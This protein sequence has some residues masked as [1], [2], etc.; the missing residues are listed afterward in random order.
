[1]PD[2]I[3]RETLAAQGI[4][5][6][7]QQTTVLDAQDQKNEALADFYESLKDCLPGLRSAE[8][9]IQEG[10]IGFDIGFR[11]FLELMQTYGYSG[12]YMDNR[13][14]VT[15][16][17]SQHPEKI[18][19]DIRG[20]QGDEVG[21]L[22][23]L[24]RNMNTIAAN[25]GLPLTGQTANA[26]SN[27]EFSL[28][29]GVPEAS[30]TTQ[31]G[32]VQ[33]NHYASREISRRGTF[34]HYVF[35]DSGQGGNSIDWENTMRRPYKVENFYVGSDEAQQKIMQPEAG[36]QAVLDNFVNIAT[37]DFPYIHAYAQQYGNR[38]GVP[39]PDETA[40]LQDQTSLWYQAVKWSFA[41]NE[42]SM[43]HSNVGQAEE[44]VFGEVHPQV[45]AEALEDAWNSD[46]GQNN[47]LLKLS[48]AQL[49]SLGFTGNVHGHKE[50]SGADK[51][52]GGWIKAPHSI[53]H[54]GTFEQIW[55]VFAGKINSNEVTASAASEYRR[56][57]GVMTGPATLLINGIV[58]FATAWS[59][60]RDAAMIYSAVLAQARADIRQAFKDASGLLAKALGW[61]P[62]DNRLSDGISNTG[63]MT[64]L[65][66]T[67][68]V[69]S[70]AESIGSAIQRNIFKEQCF[71]LSY[72]KELS[73][74]KVM[75]DKLGGIASNAPNPPMG[76]SG[77]P[78]K[79]LPYVNNT[80]NATLLVDGDPYGFLNKLTLSE[81]GKV[82][83]NTDTEVLDHLQPLIR[84]FKV[85]YDDDGV[86]A[87]DEFIFES[88]AASLDTLLQDRRRRGAGVG[89]QSF[90]F[91]Y[92][93]SN[94]FAVKKSISAT[95]KI[96]ASSMDEL[97]IPRRTK[98]NG[99]LISFAD[100][101]LKTKNPPPT[102][103]PS[104][105]GSP[106]PSCAPT[107][108]GSPSAGALLAQQ[109]KNLDKLTFRLKAVVGWAAPTGNGPWEKMPTLSS[110]A[111]TGKELLYKGIWN[112]TITLNLTP[113][114]HHFEF[115]ELGRT[116][117][118]IK[119]LAYVEDFYDQPAFNV[120]ATPG[121]NSPTANQI[122]RNMQL[123]YYS[124]VCEAER[125]ADVK[126]NLADKANEEKKKMM[127]SLVT[128]LAAQ[129]KIYTLHL[130]VENI[131]FFN[132]QG[133][134]YHWN[135][136][137]FALQ[138]DPPSN[139]NEAIRARMNEALAAYEGFTAAD[140][141]EETNVFRAGL[142]ATNPNEHSLPFVYVSDLIDCIMSNIDAELADLPSQVT[143][144]MATAEGIDNDQCSLDLEKQRLQRLKVSYEK[145][146]I[147]LGPLEI[148]NQGE[149][150]GAPLHCTFGD[151]PIS[152]KY[153]LEWIADELTE[154]AQTIYTLTRFLNDLFN[155]LIAE[156]LND[157]SCFNWDI[158][159]GGKVRMNQ[160]VITSYPR[161][162]PEDEITAAAVEI[163]LP[164]T[165]IARLPH[166]GFN[167]SGVPDTPIAAGHVS[168][169][170]NYFIYFA[171]RVAPLERMKG[172]KKEDEER[173]IFHYMAG[174]NSG[175]IKNIKFNKTDST[176]LAEVRFEQE[177][178][179]GLQQLRVLY[180]VDIDMYANVKT[181]PGTY[182]FV[183]PRGV[184]PTTNLTEGHPLN[185]T[186]YGIGGYMMIIKSEHSF[187]PGKAESKL[188]AK[189]VNSIEGTA[190][191]AAR[192]QNVDGAEPSGLNGRCE[193]NLTARQDSAEQA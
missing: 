87:E 82:F 61:L 78:Q 50:E 180:D 146:R 47:Y 19:D 144:L 22:M 104:H 91:A 188:H 173:G 17:M 41:A 14:L 67:I 111:E 100:L 20:T 97:L 105:P 37:K 148:V 113:T 160:T 86:A 52:K 171:G 81:G 130:P 124:K 32:I 6:P 84:L 143:A 147:V 132:S 114:V 46:N 119:Y 74:E 138:V 177:G 117:L 48:D 174:R 94:P 142:E 60:I 7:A 4:T 186:Q 102:R 116:T 38:E 92:E 77:E 11:E 145:L 182:I 166:P 101:A 137:A 140:E 98:E 12:G 10:W 57:L 62:G 179:E 3:T 154:T 159:P 184:A 93:G 153:L 115:D 135:A 89:I 23:M 127:Q 79:A 18:W 73:N 129:R 103:G 150:Q 66:N 34:H 109:N 155:K 152:M 136:H 56:V 69:Q 192:E 156:F 164:R 31:T 112:S 30:L 58:Q 49:L 149:P 33:G 139:N 70:A 13:S 85:T 169:E 88:S 27:R 59:C 9:K 110:R 26:E 181:F 76:G 51:E 151:V 183:D 63:I 161:P 120:F 39:N 36:D 123:K 8:K 141:A 25:F 190:E 185:L 107:N 168:E 172:N 165:N 80:T 187:A 121:A 167:I 176:G 55:K 15:F 1:M 53:Q 35:T 95:L 75:R 2:Q 64:D 126:K 43:R 178:Y 118:V 24:A 54:H 158:K 68:A 122:V 99:R 163:N 106:P 72:I 42:G 131:G 21:A 90:D 189:W 40:A 162:G 128:S 157:G 65:L 170:M 71:L 108:S 193:G 134:Y 191:Q 28:K 44:W 16:R 45:I 133:P 5:D 175:L 29:Y 83:F 96:F 125:L